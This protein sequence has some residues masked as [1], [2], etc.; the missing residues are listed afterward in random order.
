V[1]SCCEYGDE[2]SGSCASELIIY[3]VSDK[4]GLS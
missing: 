3:L 1:A 2:T 4:K